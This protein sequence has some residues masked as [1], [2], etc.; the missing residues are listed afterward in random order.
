MRFREGPISF[1]Y[2]TWQWKQASGKVE[3][4]GLRWRAQKSESYDL[5]APG[6]ENIS[7]E[8]KK[9]AKT[10]QNVELLSKYRL[11][12]GI[13]KSPRSKAQE[14]KKHRKCDTVIKKQA[15]WGIS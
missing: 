6:N 8:F 14:G 4:K 3:K 1:K 5:T 12:I 11:Q 7:F 10:T 13:D 2:S 15:F 9:R